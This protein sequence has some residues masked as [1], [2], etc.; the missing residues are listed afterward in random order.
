MVSGASRSRD[1][2]CS[3]QSLLGEGHWRSWRSA[4]LRCCALRLRASACPW[5][6]ML[7]APHGQA[8]TLRLLARA[9]LEQRGIEVVY[10][11]PEL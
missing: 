2:A 5:G 8:A 10:G 7:A 9:R 4:P 6:G 3:V 11:S 1:R